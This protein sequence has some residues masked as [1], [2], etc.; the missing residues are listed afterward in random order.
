VGQETGA[1]ADQHERHDAI[2]RAVGFAASRFLEEEDW[3]DAVDDVLAGLGRATAAS[4]VYV[5]GTHEAPDGTLL[6]SQLREWCAPGVT[7]EIDNPELQ[8]QSWE[9]AGL[10]RW[11]EV[12]AAGDL[13]YGNV[14]EFPER[15]RATLEAQQ[16]VSVL[17]A[18]IFVDRRWWGHLGFDDCAR[19][20][21]WSGAEIDALRIAAGTLGAVIQRR[22]A[23][24]TI[25]ETEDLYRTLVEQLPAVV[26]VNEV[27][28]DYVPT[29]T[30][31]VI[32][33]MLGVTA[34]RYMA[35]RLWFSLVHPDDRERVRTEDDRTDG[36]LEPFRMEYRLVRPDGGV[37]WV[38]DEAEVV[39][40]ADGEPRFWS[41]VMFDITSLKRAEE[42][43]ARALELER[44]ASTQL[45]SLDEMKNT[46]LQAVSHDLRTPLSAVLGNA[47]T[48]ERET[49]ELSEE[50]RRDLVHRIATNARK[51]ARIVTD[52]LDLDRLSRGLLEP[53]RAATDVG[54]L[55][56]RVVEE[57]EVLADRRVQVD[58]SRI[59]ATIDAPKVERI[60][61]NLIVNAARHTPADTRIWVRAE[62]VEPDGVLLSVEDEGPGVPEELR[63]AI[64]HAFEQGPTP[65]AHAP[66]SGIGLALVARFAEL[67]GGRAWVEDRE[68]GGSSFRVLLPGGSRPVDG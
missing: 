33:E 7:P 17:A 22:Q 28:A 26:Y 54:A 68:G 57:S 4:R 53:K 43:L 6:T 42:D 31:P 16:I 62:P 10:I 45:R 30:S 49:I 23:D 63:D 38:R 14:R 59:A 61:E 20:R 48:L 19:E 58:V 12:L 44:T 32:E 34:D 65:S 66:G 41:G 25:R 24:R 18:P 36:N 39:R 9:A 13:L 11:A 47:I 29:Y 67:H 51:L 3:E 2:M 52:L 50:D 15:E 40:N 37:V 55:I 46:F 8:N 1:G 21:A 60:V 5:F 64:F 56:R 35:E 27:S